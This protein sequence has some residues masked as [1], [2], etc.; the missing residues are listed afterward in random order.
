M[1]QI[2]KKN[3]MK[4]KLYLTIKKLTLAFL[5]I[6][7]ILAGV[8]VFI[9]LYEKL[10]PKVFPGLPPSPKQWIEYYRLLYGPLHSMV[11]SGIL[12]V[13][14]LIFPA[15]ALSAK[16]KSLRNGYFKQEYIHNRDFVIIRKKP[17]TEVETSKFYYP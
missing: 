6:F 12:G 3:L 1:S 16:V 17:T 2:D 13:I 8:G 5:L 15:I 7:L 14:I 10:I 11:I 9:Y 4:I